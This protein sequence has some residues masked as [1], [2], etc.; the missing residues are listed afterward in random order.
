M[1]SRSLSVVVLI[2][3]S[4]GSAAALPALRICAD[5]DNLPFS[6]RASRGFDNRI[7]ML[8]AHAVGRDPVFV[9]ARSRRGFMREQF[10][11]GAC[12]MLM[13]V[14]E[15]VRGVLTT[16]PYYRSTYVF[17]T[18]GRD[19]VSIAS[20]NDPK[21]N[22][23]RIGLQILEENY[24]PPSLPLIRNGHAAQLVGFDSFGAR[25]ADIVRAVNDGRVRTAVVWGPLAGYFVSTF[26]LP[27]SLAPVSPS[28]D[29]SG[30]P[31]AFSMSIAVHKRDIALCQAINV[32]LARLQPKIETILSAYHV[33]ELPLVEGNE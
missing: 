26:K 13:G 28:I 20:F 5:P 17:V 2:A 7:A 29:A 25:A 14:P 19:K 31:F 6:D 9:W 32:A 18:P 10:N 12:D 1:F 4:A 15:G 24:S 8:V 30:V 23:G 21:L 27:L 3:I 16:A 22:R 33:P 11:T